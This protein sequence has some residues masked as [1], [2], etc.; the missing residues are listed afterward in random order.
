MIE[1]S[2]AQR[3]PSF[4]GINRHKSNIN[5]QQA[6]HPSSYAKFL[7]FLTISFT[8]SFSLLGLKLEIKTLKFIFNT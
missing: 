5:F 7:P 6:T 1:I 4:P 8:F 2:V 3:F